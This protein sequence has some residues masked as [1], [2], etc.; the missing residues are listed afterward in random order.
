MWP[1]DPAAL[2]SQMHASTP[3]AE[4]LPATLIELYSR[5]VSL[6]PSPVAGLIEPL[7]N[8]IAG[9][10]HLLSNG[11]IMAALSGNLSTG[12]DFAVLAD[13]FI[14][15]GLGAA[16]EVAFEAAAR[17]DFEDESL[18]EEWGG[19]FNGQRCRQTMFEQLVS[20]LGFSAIV[21]T[22]T[23]RGSTTQ[24]MADRTDVPLFSCELSQRFFHFAKMRL[25]ALKNVRLFCQDSRTF[26]NEILDAGAVPGPAFFYLDAHWNQD[27]PLWDEI[28]IIFGA[29]TDA[30]V[31]VDDFRV[32]GDIGFG[33]DDYG[34]A[35]CLSVLNLRPNLTSEVELF[36][37]R[38]PSAAESGAKR[39]VVVLARRTLADLIVRGVPSL[40][41]MQWRQ[42]MLLDSIV[43]QAVSAERDVSLRGRV[44][45]LEN[46]VEVQ[47]A[48]VAEL[49]NTA[50]RQRARVAELENTAE[51]Q[52]VQVVELQ[53]A[54]ELQR[55]QVV[56][57]Q[58]AAEL[59]RVQAAELQSA[60]E[61]QRVQAA[62]L[63]SAA[64]LQRARVA[65]LEGTAER[66]RARVAELENTAE[67]Q[68]ARVQELEGEAE[69]QR[70][71]VAT[72]QRSRWRK[73]GLLL[74][75]TR[76]AGFER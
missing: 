29:R 52:R 17:M 59:Q 35:K 63:Q 16:A 9:Q 13:R 4:N 69:L 36:F 31:M 2:L 57:L 51:L 28:K 37:P 39:G 61:L 49:E 42:A 10:E 22:G 76:R 25:V 43:T 23:F 11:E 74:R 24:F 38:Y 53:S 14:S 45:E 7:M 12:D 34:P 67:L 30:V 15:F 19:P 21:E 40:D 3:T 5:L 66:Q 6:V 33:Y 65:E 32:P 47:R 27:L 60:A 1:H 8:A 73:L 71:R 64:E 55:M 46:A 48:R 20:C 26:L 50:E 56:E 58:S 62:E 54:A 75:L 18:K 70:K 44:A 41:L 72:L 68:R